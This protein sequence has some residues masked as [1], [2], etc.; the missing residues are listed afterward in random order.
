MSMLESYTVG[1]TLKLHDLI[2]PQLLKISKGIKDLDV[3]TAAL[4]KNLKG[5]GAE[6]QAMKGLSNSTGLLSKHLALAN[7]ESRSLEK[8][9]A[10]IKALNL[11]L[12]GAAM[13]IMRHP[14]GGPGRTGGGHNGGVHVGSNG[15]GFSA[16][17]FGVGEAMIPLA[18]GAAGVYETKKLY[19]SARDYE[20]VFQRFKA[21]NLGE[22]INKEA[23]EFARGAAR[24]GVSATELM[25]VLSESVGLFGSFEEAKR[26]APKISE[27]SRANQMIFQGKTGDLDEHGMMGLMKFIDRRGG[28]ADDA[29]F[30]RNLDLAERLVTGSGGRIKF[31]DLDQFSQ[32][33]GTAFRGLSDEGV[34]GMA[35]LIIEQG[36]S[37]AGVA[38]MSMYQNL[39][40]GR[41]TKKSLALM[42]ELGLGDLTQISTGNMGEKQIKS[43]VL[44]NLKGAELLQS[45]PRQWFNTVLM[46]QLADKGITDRGEIIKT[47][48]D[49]LSNRTASNQATIHSAQS[50][51]LERDYH[52]VK[53]SVGASQVIDLY[54]NTGAGAEADFEAAWTDFKTE[55]GKGVL[56]QVTSMLK[57]AADFFRDL[58]L[59]HDRNKGAFDVLQASKGLQ[60]TSLPM[61]LFGAVKNFVM[62]GADKKQGGD[63][64]IDGKKAGQVLTPHVTE[65]QSREANR[66]QAN[67]NRHDGRMNL[68]PVGGR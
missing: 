49:I 3:I 27:L 55:F 10:A 63:V 15:V 26:F 60:T 23:D 46:P 61:T 50:L 7:T 56:P 20:T 4:N 11:S 53:N 9:L 30:Q 44:Q 45:D 41:T 54:K 2:S 37:A 47:I 24:Y 57:E 52:L 42:S 59:F 48:N 31:S 12:P 16:A 33:G 35:G 1:V 39:I 28:F 21:M 19:D 40:A 17:T 14:G 25:K 6:N 65:N 13:P 43:L 68:S 38:M 58:S 29:S 51:Q 67:A 22:E 36:G 66:A 8:N 18:V 34:M 64:Y 62:G 5:I 32:R